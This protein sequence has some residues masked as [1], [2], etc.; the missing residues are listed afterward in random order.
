MRTIARKKGK[1]TYFYLQHSFRKNGKVITKEKYLGVKIP[2]DLE[3]LKQKLE[4]E[5]KNLLY[6][7]LKAIKEN[8]QEE[9]KRY[10]DSVKEK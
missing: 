10:P 4:S 1:R 5:E 9:W 2:K 8:F 3:K 7:K 6:K